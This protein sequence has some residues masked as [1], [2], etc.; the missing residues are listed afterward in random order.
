[1]PREEVQNLAE[2]V[3]PLIL[4][5]EL[6]CSESPGDNVLDNVLSVFWQVDSFLNALNDI[7]LNYLIRTCKKTVTLW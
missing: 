3:K 4:Q 5:I 6:L 2:Y 7:N 1:M